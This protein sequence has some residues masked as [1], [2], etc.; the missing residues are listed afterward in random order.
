MSKNKTLRL[1]MVRNQESEQDRA[2]SILSPVEH[3]EQQTYNSN[4]MSMI[5]FHH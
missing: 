3:N 1:K 5:S 4:T 2:I